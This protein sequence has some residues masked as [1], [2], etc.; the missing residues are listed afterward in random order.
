MERVTWKLTSSHV[1]YI[2][3][4]KI[5]QQIEWGLPFRPGLCIPDWEMYVSLPEQ[6]ETFK[7]SG[8][9]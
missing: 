6:H 3:N 5:G 2:G 9:R 7:D 8:A 4:G 1:K